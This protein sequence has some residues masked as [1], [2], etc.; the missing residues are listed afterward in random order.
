MIRRTLADSFEGALSRGGGEIKGEKARVCRKPHRRFT[1]SLSNGWSLL[2]VVSMHGFVKFHWIKVRDE[3]WA[4]KVG[5]SWRR[6]GIV[7]RSRS[8][9]GIS[10]CW[11]RSISFQHLQK[12]AISIQ[13]L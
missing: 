5:I 1:F 6:L 4:E 2:G 11:P 10:N 8:E 13:A 12:R 7:L 3:G 9:S